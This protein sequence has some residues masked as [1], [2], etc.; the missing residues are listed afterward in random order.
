MKVDY[1]N[2]DT[3]TV[4]A[5]IDDEVPGK[6][7]KGARGSKGRGRGRGRGKRGSDSDDSDHPAS[8]DDDYVSLSQILFIIVWLRISVQRSLVE[9]LGQLEPAPGEV[10]DALENVPP[11]NSRTTTAM[12]TIFHWMMALPE[13]KEPKTTV[14]TRFFLQKTG[15]P[16]SHPRNVSRATKSL[17]LCDSSPSIRV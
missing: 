13:R 7:F 9:V 4:L 14:V 17:Y 5:E 8:D 15:E 16:P 12:M 10:E 1:A 3:S 6:L 11:P 2:P